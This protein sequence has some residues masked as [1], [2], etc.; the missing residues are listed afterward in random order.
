MKTV[1]VCVEFEA[2]EYSGDESA[3]VIRDGNIA[4][5]AYGIYLRVETVDDDDR[6]FQQVRN[7]LDGNDQLH[8]LLGAKALAESLAIPLHNYVPE[9]LRL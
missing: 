5:D 6:T 3:V 7:I 9:N 4:P 2:V 8:M 1:P